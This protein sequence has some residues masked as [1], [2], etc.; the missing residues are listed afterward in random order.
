MNHLI[1]Y[2]LYNYILNRSTYAGEWVDNERCGVGIYRTPSGVEYYGQWLDGVRHGFGTL[3]HPNGEEYI[4][5]FFNGELIVFCF[6]LFYFQFYFQF[7]SI[8]KKYI[9]IYGNVYTR[10]T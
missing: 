7:Y 9:F 4:G 6:I 8:W 10:K 1:Y 5:E 2:I 3:Y